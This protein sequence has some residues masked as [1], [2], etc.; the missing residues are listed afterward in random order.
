MNFLVDLGTGHIT[1]IIGWAEAEILPFG[2]G[3]WGLQNLLGFID[4]HGWQYFIGY[5]EL[6]SIFWKAFEDAI[7]EGLDEK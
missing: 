3:L 6:E 7:G 1:G 4:M 2:C 5:T